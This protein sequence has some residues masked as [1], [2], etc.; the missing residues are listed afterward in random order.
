MIEQLSRWN[1]VIWVNPFG[2]LT[3]SLLPRIYEAKEGLTMYHPGLNF[4]PLQSLKVINDWQRL[5]QIIMYLI[6]RE[7]VPDL[8]WIDDPFARRFATYYRK[9]GAL[10]LYFGDDRVMD[11]PTRLERNRLAEAADMIIVSTPVLYERFEYT[12]KAHLVES[13]VIV[14][15]PAEAVNGKDAPVAGEESSEEQDDEVFEKEFMEDINKRLEEISRL[16]DEKIAT[17]K[18]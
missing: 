14:A 17:G 3:G 11:E 18:E 15:P 13:T 4:I 12:G 1:E 5:L 2:S 6:D 16:I 7:F 9:R 10:T 8:V